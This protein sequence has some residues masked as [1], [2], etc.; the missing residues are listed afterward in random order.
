MIF[1][2]SCFIDSN[3]FLF[4]LRRKGY[5]QLKEFLKK[6][7][8]GEIKGYINSV[9]LS[10]VFHKTAI[11]EIMENKR[12]SYQEALKATKEESELIKQLKKPFKM[13]DEII[14]FEGIE[15]LDI[16]KET[17]CEAR[18]IAEEKGLLFQDSLIA[19]NCKIKGI[20]Y[21]V[22]NDKDFERTDFLQPL[23]IY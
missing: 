21:L 8:F 10:E 22:T 16:N 5:S 1:P 20:E 2:D 17:V 7:K 6:V 18:E 4:S 14:C 13:I 9:V 15:I 23:N 11:T 3:I 12:F 19:A